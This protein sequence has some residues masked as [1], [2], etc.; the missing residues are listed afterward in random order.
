MQI[1][2]IT[3]KSKLDEALYSGPT[4]KAQPG[5]AP[6]PIGPA[7]KQAGS[8]IAQNVRDMG[9]GLKTAGSMAA[10]GAKDFAGRAA[11]I[12]PS[13]DAFGA[14]GQ[15]FAPSR[16]AEVQKQTAD[17]VNKLAGEWKQA[18]KS[19][20]RP[21]AKAAPAPQPQAQAT[22]QPQAVAPRPQYGKPASISAPPNPGAPTPAEQEKLQQR[23]AAATQNMHE[24]FNDLP[25]TKPQ[26]G[27]PVRKAVTATP[28]QIKGQSGIWSP[29]YAKHF[30]DWVSGKLKSTIPG[31]TTAV[32]L[33]T[34][35]KD[36]AIKKQLEALLAA[37]VK[38]RN[39]PATN[40]AAVKNYLM[41]AITG[42]QQA[43]A[44]IRAE[45]PKAQPAP[46][47]GGSASTLSN[48]QL[49]QLGKEII[50]KGERVTVPST[51][52]PTLDA[53]LKAAGLL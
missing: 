3:L 51:G 2:E 28:P 47:S 19:M 26:A 29:T 20:P 49:Y 37:V 21:Q 22:T 45:A 46:I 53:K 17:Y 43:S 13:L 9:K 40:D 39:D 52:S 18:V 38:S 10:S 42:L 11:S 4:V 16:E 48:A 33:D 1:H 41:T 15:A 6:S 36:P 5:S 12:A 34:V 7:I 14:L 32:G 24:A 30:Q 25:G 44:K 27:N 50:S 8:N 35:T 31:T 23:I